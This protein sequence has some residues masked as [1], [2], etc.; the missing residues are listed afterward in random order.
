MPRSHRF[1]VFVVLPL[2]FLFVGWQ[3]GASFEAQ[4]FGAGMNIGAGASQSGVVLQDPEKEANLSLMWTV[5]RLLQTHYLRPDK[6]QSQAMVEGAVRGLVASLGDPYTLFMSPKENTQFQDVLSGHLQGIGAELSLKNGE[7]NVVGVIKGSPAEKAGLV[8]KDIIIKVHDTALENMTLQDIVGLIRGKKGTS[9][10]LT[11]IHGTELKPRILTI[12]RDD[13]QVPSTQYTV[14]QGPGGSVGVLTIN[15]FGAG[16][17]AEARSIINSQVHE[18]ELKGLIIDLRYNG[19]GYLEGAVD[20]CSMFLPEGKVV[21]VERR[22]GPPEEHFV[23]RGAPLPTIPLV[24]LTNEGTASASEI[25][26]GAL[27]DHK[28]AQIIGMQSFGKGTVQEVL[29][30]PSGGSLRV[31]VARWLTPNGHDLGKLGVTPDIVI[32]RTLDDVTAG[33]DP[34]MEAALKWLLQHKVA[35]D[36]GLKK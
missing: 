24:V 8:P 31:T 32:D 14:Q 35:D 5:W 25:V 19:G 1:L 29:N 12:V 18:K 9:V 16:T 11:L 4:R 17:V 27:Q 21:T 28:R 2:L 30:L 6:L 26:A 3:M 22:D 10:T 15:E 36:A 23:S 13:I 20:L 7:V 33:K 34:Q